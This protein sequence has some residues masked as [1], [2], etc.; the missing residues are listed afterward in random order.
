MIK[1]ILQTQE[2]RR[3]LKADNKEDTPNQPSDKITL[4]T[5]VY[6]RTN[7]RRKTRRKEDIGWEN[8]NKKPIINYHEPQTK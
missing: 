4:S 8:H 5:L 7:T 2:G 6:P 1:N 3:N